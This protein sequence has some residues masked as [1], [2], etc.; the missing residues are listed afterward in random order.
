MNF[1]KPDFV[2][3]LH[4][5]DIFYHHTNTFFK[6]S[7]FILFMS[8]TQW[9]WSL[10]KEKMMKFSKTSK[11]WVIFISLRCYM[12]KMVKI[13]FLVWASILSKK[14]LNSDKM[15]FK[16]IIWLSG[17]GKK[18][19]LCKI[20]YH[21][22]SKSDISKKGISL[23][24]YIYFVTVSHYLGPIIY[25][26]K[27]EHMSKKQ[28]QIIFLYLQNVYIFDFCFQKVDNFR[29]KSKFLNACPTWDVGSHDDKELFHRCTKLCMR[30]TV[31]H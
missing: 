6:I 13:E 21:N 7:T 1:Q 26:V 18:M 20:S 10:R 25:W 29:N 22:S 16:H 19:L 4:L 28:K 27:Y 9:T 17:Y 12:I 23:R 3:V 30:D 14:K 2:T 15:Q 31:F 5:I 24:C 8:G 11:I